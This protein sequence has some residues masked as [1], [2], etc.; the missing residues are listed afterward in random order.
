MRSVTKRY[1]AVTLLLTLPPCALGQALKLR[2]TLAGSDDHLSAIALSHD[3]KTLV[4]VSHGYDRERGLKRWG[5]FRVWD[6]ETAE[7]LSAFQGHDNDV[8]SLALGPDGLTLAS[9]DSQGTILL[10]SLADQRVRS[11]H[12]VGGHS[13]TLAFSADGKKL[14]AASQATILICDIATGLTRTVSHRGRLDRMAFSPD[15]GWV[16][17]ACHQDVD[18]LDSAT[19]KIRRTLPDHHGTAMPMSVSADGKILAVDV[20]KDDEDLGYHSEIVLWDVATGTERTNL[21]G[22]GYCHQLALIEDGK[23]LVVLTE[24]KFR[25]EFYELRVLE[26]ATGKSSPSVQF[27]K[28]QRPYHLS[29]SGDGK[30]AAVACADGSICVFDVP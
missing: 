30:T 5:D 23:R 11:S 22:I 19:G 21:K 24:T 4:S 16:A 13:A 28:N 3:G 14:G 27:K 9:A 8:Y 20:S 1:L 10:W 15:L 6:V 7:I 2:T 25:S 17:T 12:A 18:I 29:L 26:A